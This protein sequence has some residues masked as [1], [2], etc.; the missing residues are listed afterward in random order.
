MVDVKGMDEVM[1]TCVCA[2][3]ALLLVSLLPML[4]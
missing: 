4:T 1:V 2:M 3:E